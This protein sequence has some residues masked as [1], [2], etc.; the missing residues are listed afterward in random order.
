MDGSHK[1][2]ALG[3]FFGDDRL[4]REGWR[5]GRARRLLAMAGVRRGAILSTHRRVMT[6]RESLSAGRFF[7]D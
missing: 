3:G 6:K 1:K 5:A 4:A 2:T 7:A